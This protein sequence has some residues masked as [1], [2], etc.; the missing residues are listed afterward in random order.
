MTEALRQRAPANVL[1]GEEMK[2]LEEAAVVLRLPSRAE[3]GKRETPQACAPN[4]PHPSLSTLAPASELGRSSINHAS[5]SRG[6]PKTITC[7]NF[8]HTA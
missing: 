4:R 6:I 2:R 8:V 7:P 3:A 1:D 5:F